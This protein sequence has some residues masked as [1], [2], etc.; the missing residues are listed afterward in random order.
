VIALPQVFRQWQ[1]D[2]DRAE[3]ELIAGG[4]AHAGG[5]DRKEI[6]CGTTTIRI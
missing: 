6:I 4:T 2:T 3:R 5:H 1:R